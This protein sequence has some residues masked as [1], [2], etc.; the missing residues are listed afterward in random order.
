MLGQN[1]TFTA[2][3]VIPFLDWLSSQW[4]SPMTKAAPRV[5]NPER[6]EYYPA[7]PG[8]GMFLPPLLVLGALLL[9]VSAGIAQE[10]KPSPA[11]PAQKPAELTV[12]PLLIRQGYSITA[13]DAAQLEEALAKDPEHAEARAKLLGY[14]FASA[15][16]GVP[17]EEVRQARLR[18]ILWLIEHHPDSNLLD[19]A[20]ATIDPS[21]HPLADADGY[22]KVKAA[23]LEQTQKHKN[24]A[25]VLGKAAWFFKTP[26][27]EIAADLLKRAHS[28]EPQAPNWSAGLGFVY[29][30][31]ILG[32]TMVNQNRFPTGVDPELAKGPAAQKFREELDKS[33]DPEVIA[34]AGYFLAFHGGILA[35]SGKAPPDIFQLAEKYLTRALASNPGNSGAQ[36]MLSQLYQ[37]LAMHAASPEIRAAFMKK[38]LAVLE[39]APAS[40]D[41][42]QRLDQLPRL[43]QAAFDAGE[44]EKAANYASESLRLAA[45]H[46]EQRGSDMAVHKANIVLGRV[47]LRQNDVEKAKACLLA[48]GH[49]HGDPGLSSFG[50]NMSLSKELLER[51][52]KDVVLHYLELCKTFWTSS[53]GQP[54]RWIEEIKAGKIPEFG[55]NLIY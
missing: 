6:R 11:T 33:D 55:P 43:A 41:S 27:K 28:L 40:S 38:R 31:G 34:T 26:D 23:W 24:S 46:Q 35:S 49:V 15:P 32:V 30:T 47:A 17:V 16:R 48:A 54:D 42:Q 4:Q 12:P 51:G 22:A 21:G 7:I 18:H 19:G 25:A 9:L 29:A 8:V 10:P 50:P 1:R 52:E 45:G 39:T 13:A 2:N 53:R 3:S 44:M 20:E 14:Y 36:V 5:A 37:T